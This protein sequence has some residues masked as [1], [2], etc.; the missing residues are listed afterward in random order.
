MK[1]LFTLLIAFLLPLFTYADDSGTCRDGLTYTY[2]E[3]TKTLTITGNGKMTDYIISGYAFP[4]FSYREDIK[5]IT[6]AKGI[7][8]IGAYAFDGCSSVTSITIPNSVTSIGEYNQEIKGE[9]NV[10][11]IFVIA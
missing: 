4:W 7:T 2:E 10:E 6:L 8:S 3:S 5:A 1:Q 9:T 11:I